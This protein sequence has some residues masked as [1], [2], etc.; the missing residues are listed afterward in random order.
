MELMENIDNNSEIND[1][2]CIIITNVDTKTLK[3]LVNF[4]NNEDISR[5]SYENKIKFIKKNK[6]MLYLLLEGANF[7]G[8]HSLKDAIIKYT[9][10]KLIK[11]IKKGP[12]VIRDVFEKIN[13]EK[14]S[15]NKDLL[16][17][18]ISQFTIADLVEIKKEIPVLII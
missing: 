9:T 11:S 16:E 10:I 13:I 6:N 1:N 17:Q 14:I 18:F 3:I 8:I 7:M 12:E 5:G 4:L 2:I 15:H